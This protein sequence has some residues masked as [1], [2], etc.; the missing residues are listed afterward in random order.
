MVAVDAYCK[1]K[2]LFGGAKLPIVGQRCHVNITQG[3]EYPLMFRGWY[4]HNNKDRYV[5]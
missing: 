1:L 4:Q 2:S 3:E 5:F